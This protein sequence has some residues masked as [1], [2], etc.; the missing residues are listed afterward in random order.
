MATRIPQDIE[1]K[2]RHLA[3][4]GRKI[5]A[6]S[7]YREATGA[8]L[9]EAKAFVDSLAVCAGSPSPTSSGLS[10]REKEIL[11]AAFDLVRAGASDPP[12]DLARRF[13]SSSR[14]DALEALR[15]ARALADGAYGLCERLRD[16]RIGL[17]ALVETL[18]R[19]HPGFSE[20]TYRKAYE[21]GMFLSR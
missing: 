3:S 12:A 9:G 15:R 7:A 5:E 4:S 21:H 16:N 18:A 2:I 8:P 13:P 14:G 19:E 11:D 1:E 20:D 17:G 6:L 10:A